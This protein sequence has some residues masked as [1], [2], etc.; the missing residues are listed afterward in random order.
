[1]KKTIIDIN[2]MS[3]SKEVYGQRP[4]PFVAGFIYSIV[5]LFVIALIYCCIGRIEVVATAAGI[6]RPNDDISSVSSVTGG[7]VTNIYYSDGQT[8]NKGEPLLTIDTSELEISLEGYETSAA[9][10]EEEILLLEKFIDGV[11]EGKNPFSDDP[12][13]KEYP[14]FV[15]F[16][17]YELAQDNSTNNAKYD[18]NR[19]KVNME[20]TSSQISRLFS[21]INGL[22]SYKQSIENGKNMCS[23][24]PEY[25]AMYLL[26]VS[27]MEALKNEYESQKIQVERDTSKDTYERQLTEYKEQMTEYGYLVDSIKNNK[28]AFPSGDISTCSLLYNDYL[29]N[30]AEYER[31]YESAR[32]TYQN[33]LSIKESEMNSI[34]TESSESVEDAEMESDYSVQST[35]SD[36][37][38]AD[39]K[40][41]MESAEAA[42]NIYKNKMLAQYQQTLSEYKVKALEV[43]DLLSAL[44]DKASKLEALKQSYENSVEQKCYQTLSQ[45]ESSIESAETELATAQ[46]NLRLYQIAEELYEGGIDE[47]GIS[48]T[49]SMAMLEQLSALLEQKDTLDNQLE[50]LNVQIKQTKQQIEQSTIVAECDGIINVVNT[51]VSGDVLSAGTVIATIIPAKETAYKMQMY[52][53]NADIANIK[54]GDSVKYNL[55]ALPSSQYGTLNGVVTKVS[56]DTIIQ[57]G[58]YSGYYLVE[59]TIENL[60]LEDKDGNSG[61]VTVGMQTEAKIVT[62]KKTIMRYLLEKI[63]LF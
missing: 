13:N 46:S 32:D 25:E 61:T 43:Q 58:Q 16:H 20:S 8:I 38:L 21:Q 34:E 29:S 27:E 51:V 9:Q 60:T 17:N 44:T 36:M 63:N 41:K 30:L 37:D 10:Y 5:G 26:Y 33:Y 39:A 54:V 19:N 57:D 40:S 56:S 14:Y 42:I 22:K 35:I 23:A 6:V 15:Q 59:G 2:E 3:D 45:I 1:M 18:V 50:G 28:S 7:R 12:E 47:N 48:N 24:Y 11:E 55:A 53:N 49:I 4:N 62:Q 52:V 31:S